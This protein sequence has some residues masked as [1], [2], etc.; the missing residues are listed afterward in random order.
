[1]PLEKNY[2]PSL[3]TPRKPRLDHV[4]IAVLAFQWVYR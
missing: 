2:K 1:M 3:L 4:S